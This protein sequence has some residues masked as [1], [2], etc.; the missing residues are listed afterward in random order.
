MND[1]NL[2]RGLFLMAIALAFGLT[3]LLRYPVG[4]FQR[5]GPGLFPALVSGLLLLVGIATVIRSRFTPAEKIGFNLRNIALVLGSLCA[6]GIVSELVNMT[7]GIVAL[8]FVATIAGSSYSVKRNAKISL[9]LVAM[10]F[11]FYKLLG[12]QLP[13]Y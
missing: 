10:A 9:G 7:A 6:F 5:A 3:S 13:L 1:R 4:D 8:V 2:L 12:V 11:A